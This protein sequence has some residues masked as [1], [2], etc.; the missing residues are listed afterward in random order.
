M[1]TL[2]G[3]KARSEIRRI[4]TL[5]GVSKTGLPALSK[6][7]SGKLY[8]LYVLSRLLEELDADGYKL[9]FSHPV[10]S[11][12]TGGGPI[13][14]GDFHVDLLKGGTLVGELYT[15]V[16]VRT[17]GWHLGRVTDLSQYHEID[18]VIVDPGAT[19][20]PAH[21]EL[22]LGIECKATATFHKSHVREALG[23]RRELSFYDVHGQPSR[24]FSSTSVAADPPSEY[25]LA[26]IDPAGSKYVQ[27]PE[28][29]GVNL[30]HWQP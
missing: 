6:L 8:E 20:F 14:P 16:E 4:L 29:F 19:G 17:L 23:R 10:V 7:A 27:S 2:N 15:D 9:R 1:S 24:V 22:M 28:V 5:L 13:K 3:K 21:G 18:I 25:W 26:F 11:F 12:K 30:K